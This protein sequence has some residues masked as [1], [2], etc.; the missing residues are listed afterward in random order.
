MSTK[1]NGY[2]NVQ[3]RAFENGQWA[4][5]EVAITTDNDYGNNRLYFG[6]WDMAITPAWLPG[7]GEL[8]I[9]SNRG[10]P[11]GS[12]N[13]LRIPAE[14]DGILRGETVLAEQTLYR[15]RPDVSPDGKRFIYSST[16]GAADQFSNLYVQPTN[17]GEPYKMTFLDH[18]AFHPRFFAG[19]GVDRLHL[20]PGRVAAVGAAGDLRRQ[21][22]HRS[23][24]RP[25]LAASDGGAVGPDHRRRVRRSDRLAGAPD[26]VRRQVLRPGRRLRAG[27]RRG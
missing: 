19:R 21:A 7:G 17:G 12:G 10:V 6:P 22:D 18:D 2:F 27:E 5:E 25:A 13:V 9:V 8:L 14:E 11:L 3:V 20:E 26:G 15:T 1:P 24:D 23:H 4:G 16:A